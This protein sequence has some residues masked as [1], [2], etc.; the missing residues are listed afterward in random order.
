MVFA[1]E[2]NRDY[3]T[4][5]CVWGEG[6][7]RQFWRQTVFLSSTFFFVFK[8]KLLCHKQFI[9]AVIFFPISL[10]VRESFLIVKVGGSHSKKGS[11]DG[12]RNLSLGKSTGPSLSLCNATFL[13]GGMRWQLLPCFPYRL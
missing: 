9:V 6:G 12:V 8:P 5:N 13:G 7:F 4:K 1:A 2:V 11:G 3:G 10:P